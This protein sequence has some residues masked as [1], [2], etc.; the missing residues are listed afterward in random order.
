MTAVSPP[1]DDS[2]T[3]QVQGMTCAACS[4]RIQ[5]ALERTPGVSSANVNLMTGSATVSYDPSRLTP[6]QLVETIRDTGYGAELPEAGVSADALVQAQ[7]EAR[8]DEIAVLRRKLTLSLGAAVVAMVIS[9]PLAERVGTEDPLM[10]LMM[11]LSALFRRVAP[12]IDTVSAD[13]WRWTLL[14][15]TLPVVGWAGRHFYTR[16]WSAFRHRSADMNTLIAVGTGAA[17]VYSLGVTVAD[18]WLAAQG[19]VPYVYYEAVVWIIALIL[20]GNLLEARAKSRTSGA[21]RRLIGLRPRTARLIR[22]EVETEIAIERLAT[23]DEVLVRPGETIPADGVVLDGT[24]HVDESMLTGEPTPVRKAAGD[25]V[26]GATLNRNGAL[27]V[28]V[29]R[30]GA[31]T[32]LSRIIGLVQ[33]AQGSKAPIQRMADRIAAVFVPAVIAIAVVTFGAL[34]RLR[35]VAAIP[36]CAGRRG[37]GARHRVSL[38]HGPGGADRRNGLHRARRGARHPD[39]GWGAAGAE[40]PHRHRG[41]RQDGHADRGRAFGHAPSRPTTRTRLLGLAAAVERR[42]EHP[43]AKPSSE[44]PPL[45]DW[46]W[47]RVEDFAVRSG[48][49]VSGRVGGREVAV[50]NQAHMAELGLSAARYAAEGERIAA[51]SATAVFVGVD[52]ELAGVI[53]VADAVKPTAPAAVAALRGMGIESIMLTGDTARSAAGVARAVGIQRVMADVLP[54]RKLE[55]IRALRAEGRSVAMVGDGLN[56]A[57]AL[58]QADVGIAMGTGT[59][60][61]MDAGDITLMRGDPAGVPAAIRL[62]RRTLR[63][64]RQNLFWAF[65]YNVV[66]IP[67]AAGAL[68]PA[69][70]LRLTPAMA[71]AA[72]VISSLS[73]VAN[74][75]RLRGQK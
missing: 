63:V 72:M 19:V 9:M 43:L 74:S 3:I 1:A 35:A 32:V 15:L 62:A 44:R 17:F 56:D 48:R 52:G 8:D 34:A 21:I 42:S 36:P 71:A 14:G 12:W 6:D 64:I 27:R 2:R 58:A 73:V 26:V 33:Q 54:D 4:A 23:G 60:V 10:R 37:D 22:D 47:S 68:Y 40:R 28:R 67:V 41:V 18:D 59:D 51:E 31:D 39:Q 25:E 65:V 70:G 55:A 38:R 61:A 5:R 69:L 75:L 30:V 49:G 46:P 45:A 57:P 24:S 7:D 11:P 20:L 16:A 53:G 66:G 50:G 13:A 29:R